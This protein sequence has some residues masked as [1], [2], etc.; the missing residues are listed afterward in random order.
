MSYIINYY[1]GGKMNK[2]AT[3]IM[4]LFIVF[5]CAHIRSYGEELSN[6]PYSDKNS[7]EYR[8]LMSVLNSR[9]EYYAGQEEFRWFCTLG[10][11][12]Y[13]MGYYDNAIENFI[14][15]ARICTYQIAYYNLGL[16]LMDIGD[17]D[18]AE[19]AFEKSL[20]RR[21]YWRP[22]ENLY[23]FDDNGQRRETYFAYYN[24]ACI[25]SLQNDI[26]ASFD[27][28]CKAI[29]NGY[30]YINHI[31]NNADLQNLF[32]HD[33]GIFRQKM[34][35]IYSE[36]SINDVAGK[37]F[38]LN[39]GGAPLEYYFINEDIVY[40]LRGGVGGD[41]SGWLDGEYEIKNY[42]IIVKNV[43]YHY[44]ES[45][46]LKEEQFILLKRD[47]DDASINGYYREVPLDDYIGRFSGRTFVLKKTN[48]EQNNLFIEPSVTENNIID[49]MK[50]NIKD[51]DEKQIIASSVK[52]KNELPL[53]WIFIGIIILFIGITVIIIIAKREK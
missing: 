48:N 41:A 21:R 14:R 35:D 13:N 45:E 49:V 27:Y 20:S 7:N 47:F 33:D 12:Y 17:F 5:I 36:G 38:K 9:D 53:F 23:T 30:P 24:I 39:W 46:G 3:K 43:E 19:I 8:Q 26:D 4:V 18:A 50:N 37:G 25:K 2:Q 15:A 29:F 16:C 32:V 44:N 52:S 28:L 6:S 51:D 22:I 31:R 10:L 11:Q 1:F 42:L 34:E 40:S